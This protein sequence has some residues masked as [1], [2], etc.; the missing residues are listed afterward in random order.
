MKARRLAPRIMVWVVVTA[1]AVANAQFAVFD[2]TS[3]AEAVQ[4]YAKVVQEVRAAETQI[5]NQGHR[6][7]E[8]GELALPRRRRRVD[9]GQRDDG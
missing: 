8:A 6:P 2:A 9:G 3:Y 1:P 7:E 4:Q 5:A